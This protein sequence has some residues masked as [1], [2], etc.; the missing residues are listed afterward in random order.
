MGR[1]NVGELFCSDVENGVTN[2]EEILCGGS[3]A[4]L[5]GAFP[6]QPT[7]MAVASVAARIRA[8]VA[9]ACFVDDPIVPAPFV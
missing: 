5:E 2:A 9:P 8:N 1:V 6:P 3:A 4:D 7:S